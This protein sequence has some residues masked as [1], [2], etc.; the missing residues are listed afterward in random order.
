MKVFK[1][2]QYQYLPSKKKEKEKEN[3]IPRLVGY[4][5]KANTHPTLGL[6]FNSTK[7]YQFQFLIGNFLIHTL[8]SRVRLYAD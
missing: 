7:N 6:Y 2:T 5:S 8:S 1:N 3:L 4:P